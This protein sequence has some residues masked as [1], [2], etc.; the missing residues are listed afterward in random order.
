MEES[1]VSDGSV[2]H[3]NNKRPT[4]CWWKENKMVKPDTC[5]LCQGHVKNGLAFFSLPTHCESRS[6]SSNMSI[7]TPCINLPSCQVSRNEVLRTQ[8]LRT[9][10]VGAH[11]SERAT[12]PPHPPPPPPP[13][14]GGTGRR[15]APPPPP[16]PRRRNML[17]QLP[18][19]LTY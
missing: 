3:V 10:L 18:G 9:H 6:R 16:P 4:M 8:K 12:P 5:F 13:P 7:Y 17:C 14:G 11:G 15:P 2:I 1:I 19:L